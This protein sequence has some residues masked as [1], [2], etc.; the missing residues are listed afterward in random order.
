MRGCRRTFR[1]AWKP[2]SAAS[3]SPSTSSFDTSPCATVA[4]LQRFFAA[5]KP[6][7]TMS[8]A[9]SAGAME[10]SGAMAPRAMRADSTMTLRT[11][12]LG[13]PLVW[14]TVWNCGLSG[15]KHITS[16]PA[17]ER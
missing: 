4:W 3:R 13:S 1:E 5:P 12:S 10:L 9:K 8:A 15:A 6:P 7:G 2:L 16:A 17:A 14:S 11:L